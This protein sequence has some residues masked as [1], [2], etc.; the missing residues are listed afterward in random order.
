MKKILVFGAGLTAYYAIKY[1][2]DHG[3]A[4]QWEITVAD[5]NQETLNACKN[6]FPGIHIA[7]VDVF[8]AEKRAAV[9][10]PCNVVISLLPNYFH[11]LVARDCIDFGV[12]LVTPS[13]VTAD[14]NKLNNE[15]I[16]KNIII[17]NELGLDPGIDHLSSMNI[18]NRLK[19]QGATIKSYKSYCGGLISRKNCDNPWEYKFTWNPYNVIRAGSDGA[20]NLEN[21]QLRYVPYH[22]LFRETKIIEANNESF[23]MYLNRDSTRYISLYGLDQVPTFLRGTLRYPGFCKKWNSLVDAGLTSDKIEMTF[24][25]DISWDKFLNGFSIEKSDDGDTQKALE[26]LFKDAGDIELKTATPAA[27]LQ[28]LLEKKWKMNP[29]DKDRVVMLHEIEYEKD[30]RK[31]LLKSLMDLEGE[32][33]RKS[34]M[35]KTVGLPLAIA[36]GLI[37]DG[38]IKTFGVILPVI[39]EVYRP[40]LAALSS[41]DIEFKEEISVIS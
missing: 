6:E 20:M 35:A 29:A 18:I 19:E 25:N 40:V 10:K 13:Y 17:L 34:A 28:K 39:S 41:E 26:W 4:R 2:A 38:I 8:D 23:E 24:A 15:T 14:M 32:D 1:L 33:A 36:A 7:K 37:A 22:R 12:H 31:E 11:V 5:A 3:P 16:S 9:I 27:N 21:N 30:G